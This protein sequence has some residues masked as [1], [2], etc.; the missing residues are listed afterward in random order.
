MNKRI[1][2]SFDE[3]FVTRHYKDEKTPLNAWNGDKTGYFDEVFV[4]PTAV[5]SF[6]DSQLKQAAEGIRDEKNKYHPGDRAVAGLEAAAQYL[7]S[8][9]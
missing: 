6:F 3:R 4:T 1:E 5:K 2:Q 8:L 9:I 7:E